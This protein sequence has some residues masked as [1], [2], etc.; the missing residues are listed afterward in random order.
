MLLWPRSE[1]VVQGW[2]SPGEDICSIW[3]ETVAYLGFQKGGGANFRWPPVLTQ[4]G[5]GGQTKFSNFLVCQNKIF[6]PKGAW[7]NDLPLNTPLKG[8]IKWWYIY[9]LLYNPV[10]KSSCLLASCVENKFI[11]GT[12]FV[13]GN[14][15]EMVLNI[16]WYCFKFRGK[17][18]RSPPLAKITHPSYPHLG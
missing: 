10:R 4:R 9:S 2:C 6:L 18:E 11:R 3:R 8:N 1:Q 12:F 17:R 13:R 16:D 5:G 15:H 14:Y 7:P